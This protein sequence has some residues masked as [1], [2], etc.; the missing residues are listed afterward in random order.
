METV[1]FGNER[2]PVTDRV[3]V[4]VAG[5]G[6]AGTFAGIASARMGAKTLIIEQYGAAG[7]SQTM[8][9]VTPV[10]PTGISGE[11]QSS[12][13]AVEVG[14]RLEQNHSAIDDGS[15]FDPLALKLI[16]DD[17]IEDSGCD[18][19][20]QT[21]LVGVIKESNHIK[22]AVVYNNDGIHAI[23]AEIFI[24]CTGDGHLSNMSGAHYMSG[25][26]EGLN[27]AI[28][29]RFRMTNVDIP[30]FNQ[31]LIDMG[32]KH[33][34]RK[35]EDKNGQK[36][37]AAAVYHV[38]K[39]PL[40][41]IFEEAYAKGLMTLQDIKY[42]Q[43]FSTPGKPLDLCFNC[44]SMESST[45]T[46]DARHLSDKQREGRKAVRRI[47][48]FLIKNIPGFEEAYL[49]EIAPML[50][51]RDSRRI[52]AEYILTGQ[53]VLNHARFD[54]YIAVSNYP[55]DVHDAGYKEYGEKRYKDCDTK[56]HY[57]HVPLRSLIVKGLDNLFV[58]GRCIG[59]DFLAQSTIRI[60]FTCR[61]TGEA[62]G[63]S[64]ALAVKKEV[65]AKMIEGADVR[66][67]MSNWGARFVE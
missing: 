43:C 46:L 47:T 30:S 14:K 2:I 4:L 28:S 66:N 10:M 20:Y 55:M 35:S 40:T 16:L 53:D 56:E 25:N 17:M 64:A 67:V 61:A 23:E 8:A 15:W 44:P 13:L 3:E 52:T 18:I 60:Q 38:Y 7:G 5:A 41:R 31:Y 54:D 42:F 27:Q 29:L 37:H 49:C 62:A 34:F 26:D 9:L 57:Y 48:D 59:A 21:T 63:I 11:P 19:L 50:G 12:A 32:D 24:D 33:T 6:T 1:M 51:I 36:F 45:N 39:F 58:A 22:Y 65:C